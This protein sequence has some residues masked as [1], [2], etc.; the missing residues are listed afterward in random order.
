MQKRRFIKLER[1]S[2]IGITITEQRRYSVRASLMLKEGTNQVHVSIVVNV[3][4]HN[5]INI[6]SRALTE[7]KVAITIAQDYGEFAGTEMPYC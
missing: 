7:P 6:F 2:K 1:S 5:F 4:S 3:S